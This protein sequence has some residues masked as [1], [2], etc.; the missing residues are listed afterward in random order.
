MRSSSTGRHPVELPDEIDEEARQG[1]DGQRGQESA[2]QH[3]VPV[4]LGRVV[5]EQAP[6]L[7]QPQQ[8]HRHHVDHDRAEGDVEE[9]PRQ[10]ETAHG[11][12]PDVARD[13]A[14]LEPRAT[15]ADDE[16]RSSRP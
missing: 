16:P 9:G 1:E 13:Q 3:E 8:A 2:A 14:Q 7:G 15:E 5:P 6:V 11:Q 10:E 12:G 4:L